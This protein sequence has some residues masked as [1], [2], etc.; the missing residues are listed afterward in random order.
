MAK[1]F[2]VADFYREFPNDDACLDHLMKTRF[3]EVIDCPK[4]GKRGKFHRLRK[5][6]AFSCQWCGHHLHPMVGT[7]FENTH[8]PL[9]KW[10]YAIYLF[11]TSR[12]GVP[13]KELQRQLGVT[14]KTAWRMG[15]EIR[16]YMA[17]VDGNN[18]LSGTIEIDDV[19]IGGHRPGKPGRGA[20]GKTLM[21]GM[22]ERDG[23]VIARVVPN[24]RKNTVHPI[25]E[26]GIEKG[27]TVY[28]DEL[29]SYDGLAA[30]GYTHEAVNHG[31]GE[32][33]RGAC[34]TNTIEGY[35]SRLKNSIRGT[36]VHVSG[37][38]LQKYAGEFE[39]GFT[40]LTL[41]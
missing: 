10:L 19:M 9:Q 3:G 36:H 7:P 20:A 28:S 23:E 14:Y 34:H 22:V 27:S 40:R 29:K 18:P 16:K 21:I 33:V 41:G 39:E 17:S 38:H 4:C 8:T 11:T 15:H 2:T 26:D 24:V 31:R 12:H 5:E 1:T 13:A 32:Y 25:I 37:K 35:W 6:P 30:K